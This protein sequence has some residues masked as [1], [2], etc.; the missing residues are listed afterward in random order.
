MLLRFRDSD[1]HRNLNPM[2]RPDLNLSLRTQA[3]AVEDAR[4]ENH[5]SLDG[6]C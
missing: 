1:P 3:T 5:A 6:G 4:E 2:P